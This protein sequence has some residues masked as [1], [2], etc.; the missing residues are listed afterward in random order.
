LP[1]RQIVFI[2]IGITIIKYIEAA[3]GI[4]MRHLR[5]YSITLLMLII[6]S[7]ATSG[8]TR[9][10]LFEVTPMISLEN[11]RHLTRLAELRFDTLNPINHLAW[12]NDGTSITLALDGHGVRISETDFHLIEADNLPVAY[13]PAGIPVSIEFEM[14]Y[15]TLRNL[16]TGDVLLIFKLSAKEWTKLEFSSDGSRLAVAYEDGSIDVW[17]IATARHWWTLTR[18]GISP[19]A[20][21]FNADGTLLTSGDYDNLA[22]LWDMTTGALQCNLSWADNH[23]D[24]L[25][26]SPD[27]TLLAMGNWRGT[28]LEMLD[29]NK[30]LSDSTCAS[31][32]FD[33][34]S[35]PAYMMY[36]ETAV[37]GD[38]FELAFNPD[39]SVLAVIGTYGTPA[40]PETFI[41][42]R[43]AKTGAVIME[44][45]FSDPATDMA[46]S[47]DGRLL[48]VAGYNFI[49]V[50]GI[51]E[52]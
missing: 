28:I 39:G 41:Q 19:T 16:N 4:T 15:L 27:G 52:A 3:K 2:S 42:L 37:M 22:L 13:T 6:V 51:P 18:H 14:D 38:I 34:S 26:F 10:Q 25:A 12:S 36:R 32:E 20:L 31:D 29:V 35:P 11:A 45:T 17:D 5:L 49:E 1:N 8:V 21:A 9:S 44:Q 47:P 50:W 7:I 43:N 23:V 33:R 48:A 40:M 46:F 24:S 30:I